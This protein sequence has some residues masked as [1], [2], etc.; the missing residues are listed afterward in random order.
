MIIEQQLPRASQ[1]A[2]RSFRESGTCGEQESY[3]D[4]EG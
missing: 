1:I 3:Q 4:A 2:Q